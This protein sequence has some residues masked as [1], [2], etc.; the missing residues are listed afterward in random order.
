[1]SKIIDLIGQRFGRL[2]VIEKTD[3]RDSSKRIIWRCRCDCGNIKDVSS[4]CLVEHDVLSCGC[5]LKEKQEQHK[6]KLIGQTFG[7]LIVVDEVHSEANYTMWKCQC[8]CGNEIVVRGNNLMY[9]NTTSCG[10][11]RKEKT[12][13]I[14]YTDLCGQKFGKLTVVEETN[15]RTAGGNIVWK[16]LC[17]CGRYTLVDTGSL[18]SGHTQSCGCIQSQGEFKI[19]QILEEAS[20]T[21]KTH[22]SFDDCKDVNTLPFDFFVNNEYLIEYDGIQHFLVTNKGWNTNE[23]FTLLHRH[24]TI[25]NNYCKENNIPLIRIPYTYYDDISLEDLLVNTTTFLVNEG[26]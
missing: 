12:R 13:Y 20:I 8:S 11:K 10:C 24:D 25:K 1:M 2:V 9:G 3:K 22:Y 23:H 5:L 16:C 14:N 21:F 18:R 7:D 15:V 19:K 4:K 26:T 17:D 6:L